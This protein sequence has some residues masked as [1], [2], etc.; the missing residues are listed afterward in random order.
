[1]IHTTL[2]P[3]QHQL[4][5][6]NFH[7]S[8][9]CLGTLAW[10]GMGLGKTLSALWAA[11]THI[12]NLQSKGVK[13]PKVLILCPKSAIV[14]WREE[15]R[16]NVKELFPHVHIYAVSS[17]HHAISRLKYIDTRFIII[18]ESHALKSP[19]TDRIKVMAT[20]LRELGTRG[21]CFR[22]G[23]IKL[24]T[25]TPMPNG[26]HELYTSWALC[27]SP[28]VTV[29][30]DR[31]L[32]PKRYEE[33][34]QSF[35]GKKQK[36]F[37]KG[38]GKKT[39]RNEAVGT[40]DEQVG[41]L[42][43][44]LSQFTHYR[45]VQD[46]LDIPEA[47]EHHV[48]LNLPDDKLLEDADI[49]KPEAYM[50]LVE[51]LSRAKTPHMLGWIQQFM[52]LNP[53]TQL[54]VFAMH[55][56]PLDEI[57][58]YFGKQYVR[59]ITG[60][61]NRKERDQNIF[62][63]KAGRFPIFGMTFKCGSESLNLQNA[64]CSLYHGYPWT[65]ATLRQAMARTYRSGQQ[66]ETQH[67]FLTSGYNDSRILSLVRAK[68]EATTAVEDRLIEMEKSRIDRAILNQ[69]GRNSFANII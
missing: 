8:N 25:G 42:C 9:G 20:L 68:Q 10:H 60:R 59:L 18:D 17:V 67:Y 56:A 21:N 38:K 45:R 31:I 57:V 47:H 4:E 64:Y 26:A 2:T 5:L 24:L 40:N 63:F 61:E 48:N 22:D 62:D 58:N 69:A 1:M 34:S 11:L 13:A 53:G 28:N 7:E 29:A 54:I 46:C 6:I 44:L 52:R 51:R 16:K 39:T 49:E 15:I 36:T 41:N 33:W 23:R 43:T 50:A 12:K 32:D 30:A 55:R 3:R 37:W 27:T 65:D 14:T 35:A 66:R 19:T